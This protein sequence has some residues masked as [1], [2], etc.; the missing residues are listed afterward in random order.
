MI[1]N[2]PR[3]HRSSKSFVWHIELHRHEGSIS[4]AQ[5]RL[6]AIVDDCVGDERILARR[7]A[8]RARSHWSYQVHTAPGCF[9]SESTP[10]NQE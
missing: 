3:L 2:N 4:S 1:F 10:E 6:S 8:S 5:A 9:R 7:F